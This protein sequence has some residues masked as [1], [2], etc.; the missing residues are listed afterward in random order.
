VH[1]ALERH[2]LRLIDTAQD[3]VGLRPWSRGCRRRQGAQ[4]RCREQ[5]RSGWGKI[6]QIQFGWFCLSKPG[7]SETIAGD[8]LRSSVFLI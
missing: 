6:N 8:R 3:A 7:E 5:K 1:V 2:H 4:V